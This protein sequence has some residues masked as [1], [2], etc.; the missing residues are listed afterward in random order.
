MQ[1]AID[2]GPVQVA[3]ILDS[4]DEA[5]GVVEEVLAEVDVVGAAAAW[6][7]TRDWQKRRARRD[8]RRVNQAA[9]A[10]RRGLGLHHR[11]T[12]VDVG[13]VETWNV[14]DM[15]SN[16][17]VRRAQRMRKAERDARRTRDA[18]WAGVY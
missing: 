11:A 9:I 17:A 10:N 4:T 15:L 16:S 8:T 1:E 13:R 14:R 2:E 6:R 3:M 12:N 5:V 7:R 18:E